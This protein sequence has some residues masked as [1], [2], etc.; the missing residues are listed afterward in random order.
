MPA[1]PI[2]NIRPLDRRHRLLLRYE[3]Y[4]DGW[5]ICVGHPGGLPVR[6]LFF[7]D[8]DKIV[9]MAKR[10]GALRMLE[11]RHAFEL[12]LANGR[13]AVD[14]ELTDAQFDALRRPPPARRRG[15]GSQR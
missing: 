1:S 14:L 3:R 9:E 15:P 7:A 12:G 5:R 10:G 13:G 6:E 4:Q 2:S 8:S 11:D